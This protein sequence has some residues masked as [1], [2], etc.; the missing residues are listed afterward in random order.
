[1]WRREE[2]EHGR[3][4]GWDPKH[5]RR[6]LDSL[7]KPWGEW[8]RGKGRGRERERENKKR[9]KKKLEQDP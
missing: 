2:E 4:R 3:A 5:K 6:R 1:M 7:N 8:R 9:K